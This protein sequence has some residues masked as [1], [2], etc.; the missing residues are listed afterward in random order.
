MNRKNKEVQEE[1]K[2]K[3]KV[4]ERGKSGSHYDLYLFKGALETVC[5]NT[6]CISTQ[7]LFLKS[8]LIYLSIKVN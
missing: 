7:I 1:I 3:E 8:L 4:K 5:L 2:G 6:V